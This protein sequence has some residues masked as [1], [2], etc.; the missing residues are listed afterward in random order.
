MLLLSRQITVDSVREEVWS[1]YDAG[2]RS[3]RC[4][5]ILLPPVSSFADIFFRQ[6]LYLASLGYRVI[7]V[8][9]PSQFTLDLALLETQPSCRIK[10]TANCDIMIMLNDII[11]M[12]CVDQLFAYCK[13][14]TL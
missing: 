5:L 11:I 7:A 12:C 13:W 10:C 2:P 9:K 8:R 4:P 14:S 6:I 3:V 1:I